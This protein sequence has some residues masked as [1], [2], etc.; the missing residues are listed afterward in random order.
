MSMTTITMPVPV[1][2]PM[3]SQSCNADADADAGAQIRSTARPNQQELPA[4][5]LE[6]DCEIG[7]EHFERGYSSIFLT[8][9]CTTSRLPISRIRLVPSTKRAVAPS[10]HHTRPTT[11]ILLHYSVCYKNTHSREEILVFEALHNNCIQIAMHEHLQE[12]NRGAYLA[13]RKRG[14]R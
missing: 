14:E 10:N 9:A 7:R 2:V 3:L 1:P 4:A 5:S 8:T 13:F 6:T 12:E 11:L